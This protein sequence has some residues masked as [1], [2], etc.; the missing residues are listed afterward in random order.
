M[1]QHIRLQTPLLPAKPPARRGTDMTKR[2]APNNGKSLA[3]SQ[4]PAQHLAIYSMVAQS[5]K[6]FAAIRGKMMT[7]ARCSKGGREESS[8]E[9][10][11][12]PHVGVGDLGAKLSKISRCTHA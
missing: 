3:T 9:F 8:E 12:V 7:R 4:W 11:Q 5:R 10:E 1:V 6:R 2:R